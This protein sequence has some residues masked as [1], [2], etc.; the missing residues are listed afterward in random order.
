[1]IAINGRDPLVPT[2]KKA[3]LWGGFLH[4]EK[5]IQNRSSYDCCYHRKE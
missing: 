2:I 1:M 3:T 5:Y 4:E